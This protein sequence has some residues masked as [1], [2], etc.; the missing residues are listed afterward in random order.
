[1]EDTWQTVLQILGNSINLFRGDATFYKILDVVLPVIGFIFAIIAAFQLQNATERGPQGGMT[2]PLI[3][4]MIGSFFIM[5]PTLINLLMFTVFSDGMVNY[6]TQEYS[7][8]FSAGF[9]ADDPVI[10]AAIDGAL[11][12]VQFIGVIAFIK[13]FLMIREKTL[14]SQ[15]HGGAPYMHIIGGIAGLNVVG[16]IELFEGQFLA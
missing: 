5:L 2:K 12:W 1:M 8:R 14:N 4:L 13:G 9:G 6:N 3:N 11:L 7:E 15:P 16:V 10:I